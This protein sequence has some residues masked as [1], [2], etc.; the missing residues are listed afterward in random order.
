MR[1]QVN[2]TIPIED[3]LEKAAEFFGEGLADMKYLL[4]TLQ[5]IETKNSLSSEP[6]A[7]HQKLDEIRK[8]LYEVDSKFN[9]SMSLIGAYISHNTTPEQPQQ[10]HTPDMAQLQTQL[11]GLKEATSQY[12]NQSQ[13]R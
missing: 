7:T 8:R 1:V 6:F 3:S 5:E 13:E 4:S 2:Y 9:N 11:E 10:S 12:A